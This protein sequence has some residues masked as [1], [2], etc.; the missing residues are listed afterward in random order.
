MKKEGARTST[1]LFVAIRSPTLAKMI[2]AGETKSTTALRSAFLAGSIF[3][4]RWRLRQGE[5]RAEIRSRRTR[6]W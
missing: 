4:I 2:R 6:S 5:G 1:L 3:G